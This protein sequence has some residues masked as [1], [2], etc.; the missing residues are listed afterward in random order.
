MDISPESWEV[1]TRWLMKFNV[2]LT[3]YIHKHDNLTEAQTH[4]IGIHWDP[5]A[6]AK[7]RWNSPG[8]LPPRW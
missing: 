2:T 5:L 1:K 7:G 8:Q 6:R 4:A 3:I